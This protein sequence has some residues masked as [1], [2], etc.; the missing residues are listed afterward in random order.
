MHRPCTFETIAP[1]RE[2]AADEA[3]SQSGFMSGNF[4][5]LFGL[6]LHFQEEKA[7]SPVFQWKSV[8]SG[9]TYLLA[10]SLKYSGHEDKQNRERAEETEDE[11]PRAPF[12]KKGHGRH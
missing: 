8:S 12:T 4:T 6:V 1:S 3:A 10:C 5:Q 7:F 2:G 11:E 9:L